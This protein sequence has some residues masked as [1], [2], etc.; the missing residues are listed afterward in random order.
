MT[1]ALVKFIIQQI[2]LLSEV[3]EAVYLFNIQHSD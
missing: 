1:P 3:C 2:L